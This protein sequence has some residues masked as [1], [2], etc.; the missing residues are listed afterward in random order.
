ML[1]DAKADGIN[2]CGELLQ[3]SMLIISV[4]NKLQHHV[5]HSMHFYAH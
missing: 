4:R 2:L 1:I 5:T 3:E